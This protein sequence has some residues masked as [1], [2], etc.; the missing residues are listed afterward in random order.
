[1]GTV[2]FTGLEMIHMKA[3]GANLA[4]ATA[5]SR[6]IPA[7]ILKRSSRVIPGFLGTPAGITTRRRKGNKR[8]VLIQELLLLG[9]GSNGFTLTNG[10]V[11]DSFFKLSGTNVASDLGLGVDMTKISSDT[12]SVHDIVKR[13]VSNEIRL[14]QEQRER[15]ANTA[16]GTTNSNFNH[17]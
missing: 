3:L 1:M 15:L 11:F 5:R 10:R 2:E 16:S 9:Q 7:L 14:L 8:A 13:Q 4:A 17:D 6:T 12:R